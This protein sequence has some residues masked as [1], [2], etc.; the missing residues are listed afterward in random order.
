MQQPPS[1]RKRRLAYQGARRPSRATTRLSLMLSC[2][3]DARHE[4]GGLAD[5]RV[6]AWEGR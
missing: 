6:G 3:R 4:D 2:A 1:S 5:R